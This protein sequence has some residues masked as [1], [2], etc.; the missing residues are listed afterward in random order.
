[1]ISLAAELVNVNG[2]KMSGS[3][4]QPTR[5]VPVLAPALVDAVGLPAKLEQPS[6]SNGVANTPAVAAVRFR[7]RRRV[8]PSGLES[9]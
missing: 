1:M 7:N 3:E 9:G 4:V 6:S 8:D 2:F 5:S